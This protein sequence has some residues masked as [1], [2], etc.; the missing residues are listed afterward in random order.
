MGF[1]NLN[2]LSFGNGLLLLSFLEK[3]GLPGFLIAKSFEQL[4]FEL[5]IFS[6]LLHFSTSQS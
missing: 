2:S 3:E 5:L 6:S 1:F 4:E